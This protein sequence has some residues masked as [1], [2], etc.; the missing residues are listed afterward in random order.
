L[1]SG[2]TFFRSGGS[3]V[4]TFG[5]ILLRVPLSDRFELRASNLS[6]ARANAAGGGAEGLLDP[7]FGFKYRF[8]TGQP[9]KSPDWAVVWQTTVPAGQRDLWV[10]RSQPT[11]KLAGYF[12][13]TPIDGFGWNL[14]LSSLGKDDTEFTQWAVSAYWARTLSPRAGAFV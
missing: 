4:Q 6:L 1:E 12:Q 3:E 7:V 11:A 9:G 10:G 5:E 13:A 8:Q 2:Y 14:A